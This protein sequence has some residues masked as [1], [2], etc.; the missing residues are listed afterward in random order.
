MLSKQ[1]TYLIDKL[2]KNRS[3]ID[4]KS[5]TGINIEQYNAVVDFFNCA[6]QLRFACMTRVSDALN[7]EYPPNYRKGKF[8]PFV[9]SYNVSVAS[10]EIT[11]SIIKTTISNEVTR[12]KIITEI[13]N[14]NY[15]DILIKIPDHEK[16]AK[17]KNI[18]TDI[19]LTKL[20]TD[21]TTQTEYVDQLKVKG[22]KEKIIPCTNLKKSDV[23]VSY[24]NIDQVIKFLDFCSK[25][26]KIISDSK[27]KFF[28][29]ALKSPEMKSNEIKFVNDFIVN[30]LNNIYDNK[31]NQ[32]SLIKVLFQLQIH[33][34]INYCQPLCDSNENLFWEHLG[35]LY[36]IKSEYKWND[37]IYDYI[38]VFH[39]TDTIGCVI[40]SIAAVE[41][42]IVTGETFREFYETVSIDSCLKVG[43]HA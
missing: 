40:T 3:I 6:S 24:A 21:I 27:M 23:I 28:K 34:N 11:E 17:K 26:F 9:F 29:N 41:F 10:K 43:F 7:N 15:Q 5:S 4:L 12:K 22:L 13:F 33:N 38:D 14:K 2:K 8:E 39:H 25:T 32:L 20:I 42:D 19:E 18:L 1:I 36:S 35:D 37:L 16:L 30:T 31:N